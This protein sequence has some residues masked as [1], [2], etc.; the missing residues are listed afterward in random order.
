[1]AR[2]DPW[3]AAL[4]YLFP[5]P[6]PWLHDPA[7]WIHDKLG[8]H[9]WSKQIEIAQALHDHRK[10]A[11]KAC[12]GPGKSYLGG[13]IICW[14]IDVHPIGEAFAASTAPSDPQVKA[15]LW[16]EITRA[17]RKGNLTGRVTL[18]A[19]WKTAT[20]DLVAYGRKP[21]DHDEHGFQGIHDR[22]VLV[23]LDEACGI[24]KTLWTATDTLVTN[25][26]ARILAIGN[27]DDPT[28]EFAQV[29]AGSPEDG[30]SG[31]SREG[32]WVIG[33]SV[34]DTP[35][36]TGEPVPDQLR[37]LLPSRVWVEERKLN[38]GEGSPLYTSKVLGLF[39]E[40]A[41]DGVIPWS[42]LKRCQGEAATAGVGPLRVP[43][44]LGVDVG[45]SEGGD[46]TVIMCRQG[47]TARGNPVRLRTQ[48]SEE[49]VDAVIA[50]VVATGATAVKVDV[51]G[52]GFGVAGS[53]RRRVQT[54][55]GWKVAVIG[56]NVAEAASQPT[57]FVNKRAEMWWEIGREWSKDGA[58]DL[59]ELADDVL[60]EL[61]MPKYRE[62]NGR[63]QIEGK[64]DIRKRLG[65]SP[66]NAD[67][68]L[69]AFL[70]GAADR[71]PTPKPY[72]DR[73]L[74]SGYRAR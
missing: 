60:N 32:W 71:A 9:L 27:P 17:H 62:V 44:E 52:V 63:V 64:E 74:T 40:D 14:W 18:D 61:A 35:N 7:G 65:R 8:E 57:R 3:A 55:V 10:V 11:V 6:N 16:R 20:G 30:T 21:A 31:M 45:A 73:R 19:Q 56:V 2:P 24:P 70:T 39:P 46:E 37:Q 59:S 42:W 72:Q 22:Y 43:V 69:L 12:H 51:I 28:S 41:S 54:E 29:C 53:L 15:I 25:E 13:R 23:V 48:E 50:E 26:D 36:F 67:A 68:V 58:W 66:D 38:W 34:F 49:I 33:I 47:P 4:N 5:P 1:M